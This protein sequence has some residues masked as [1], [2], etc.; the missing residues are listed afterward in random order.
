MD[1][2]YK[3]PYQILEEQC[4]FHGLSSQERHD[5]MKLGHAK[6]YWCSF[7]S[8]EELIEFNFYNKIIHI[9]KENK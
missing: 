4:I 2:Q 7:P 3:S 1:I 8:K 5:V 6:K 9:K